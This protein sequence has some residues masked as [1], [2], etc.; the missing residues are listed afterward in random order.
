MHNSIDS[1]EAIGLDHVGFIIP[2]LAAS[3]ELFTALGF[4]LTP[5]A[6]HTRTN[7][8]GE[9]VSAGSS[10]HSIMLETGYVELMQ[11]TDPA[12]GHQLT[13]AI[14]ARYGLHV[15]AL[16]ARDAAAWHVEC[17]RRDLGVGPL[18]NW[19]RP[20]KTPE[21]EGLARFCFFDAPWQAHDPSYLCWVQ[22]LTPELVRSPALLAHANGAQALVGL[23]YAGPAAGL[24]A[25]SARLQQAGAG[26]PLQ[27]RETVAGDDAQASLTLPLRQAKL[28]LEPDAALAEVR[29]AALA[30]RF[31][32]PEALRERALKLGL[33]CL[34]MADGSAGFR[35]D[36]RETCGL[37]LEAVPADR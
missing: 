27:A 31:A 23:R 22:H 37:F 21:R 15:L 20:V 25:W 4:T 19:S 32:D 35:V 11:I 34:P 14:H 17:Q 24:Q 2:D 26:M 12:A 36:L 7:A 3:A 5:R 30:L 18:M 1:T 16:E 13:P 6:D 29:P 8:A 28:T 9:V 10:Q 33:R